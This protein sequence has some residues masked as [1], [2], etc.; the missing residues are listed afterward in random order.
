MVP[1]WGF[2]DDH[3]YHHGI[4]MMVGDPHTLGRDKRASSYDMSQLA[5]NRI[6]MSVDQAIIWERNR[7]SSAAKIQPG[8]VIASLFSEN[9]SVR[10]YTRLI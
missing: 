7:S 3:N 6:L 8:L 9:L 1:A 10:I 5:S 4:M 2:G